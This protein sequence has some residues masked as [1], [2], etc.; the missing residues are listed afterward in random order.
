MNVEEHSLMERFVEPYRKGGI[1]TWQGR[2]VRADQTYQMRVMATPDRV[3]AQRGDEGAVAFV[4]VQFAPGLRDVTN[5]LLAGPPGYE[6]P[7]PEPVG[8]DEP[9]G[10]VD[11]SRVMVVHGRNS[12]MRDAMFAF[13]R[14]LGLSPIE[15][16]DAI[17]ETRTGSPHNLD[18]VRAA[19]RSAQA[20]VVIFTPE[21]EARL[22]PSLARPTE[23]DE[24][25]EL[26]G[27]PRPNVLLEAG[28][29]L[30][31]D[32]DRTILVEIG[33][34]R[35]ASDLDGLNTVRLS[36]ESASRYALRNR[37]ITAE[38]AVGETGDWLQPTSG[39]DF[40]GA[41]LD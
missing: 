35:R 28:M 16:E 19:M 23:P 41:L 39:G 2:S 15:W 26:R 36:N 38:C 5:E 9:H 37:L 24:E 21:D 10:P 1:I 30:A 12:A 22:L 40:D 27:Q 33:S 34:I 20:V 11:S 4:N 14:A 7:P 13:L 25:K 31:V 3:G 8:M 32:S 29:A 6:A 17:A 18:A